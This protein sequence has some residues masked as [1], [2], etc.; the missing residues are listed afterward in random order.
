MLT[1]L[2]TNSGGLLAVRF[3]LGICEA[4]IAPGLTVAVAMWYRQ[5]EQP[6]RHGVWFLGNTTAGIIGGLVAYGIGHI[7]TIAA[8]KV[9]TELLPKSLSLL[10][11]WILSR[12]RTLPLGY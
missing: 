1:A 3:F 8:W 10:C 6:L 4:P 12:L 9:C 2:T 11:F 5:A 7:E